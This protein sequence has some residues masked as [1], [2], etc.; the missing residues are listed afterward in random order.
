[1]RSLEHVTL[2]CRTFTVSLLVFSTLLPLSGCGDSGS[3]NTSSVDLT[4]RLI[5]TSDPTP[6]QVWDPD[7][8]RIGLHASW[9]GACVGGTASGTGTL[10]FSGPDGTGFVAGTLDINDH[11]IPNADGI[12]LKETG[13]FENGM[14]TGPIQIKS[15]QSEQYTYTGTLNVL[16]GEL[17]GAGSLKDSL[18]DSETSDSF[19]GD[20][21]HPSMNGN[22]RWI[23]NGN[24]NGVVSKN[25]QCKENFF[26]YGKETDYDPSGNIVL[27]KEGAF[28]NGDPTV[29]KANAYLGMYNS[30]FISGVV[31]RYDP[32]TGRT[33][34]KERGTL[35]GYGVF[36]GEGEYTMNDGEVLPGTWVDGCFNRKYP[37]F[38][39]DSCSAISEAIATAKQENAEDEARLQG[40]MQQEAQEDAEEA[41]R[42]ANV[43]RQLGG[44]I[45]G[46]VNQSIGQL[47]QAQQN[48]AQVHEQVQQELASRNERAAAAPIG[49]PP[50][51]TTY[52]NQT[53]STD[54]GTSPPFHSIPYNGAAYTGPPLQPCVHFSFKSDSVEQILVV[55]NSCGQ[56][57]IVMYDDKDDPAIGNANAEIVPPGGSQNT[58]ISKPLSFSGTYDKGFAVCPTNYSMYDDGNQ[59]YSMDELDSGLSY[60]CRLNPPPG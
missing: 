28:S 16:N 31:T 4:P 57:L 8:N 42:Q 40:L 49:T 1:M 22:C 32:T 2:A 11:W 27:E 58:A 25:G 50:P 53:A 36:Q 38:G 43:N 59:P 17:T 55:S 39:F 46:G 5:S 9:S 18:D 24:P 56:T 35:G 60:T 23:D 30:N 51:P 6:C 21:L 48:M 37:Q 41:Q 14:P 47:A 45:A 52:D 3:A 7:P 13:T 29:Y 33:I 44:M 34:Y 19:S 15:A 54:T 26:I 10:V 20:L 12:W